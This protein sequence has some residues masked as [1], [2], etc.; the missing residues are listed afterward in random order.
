MNAPVRP[1]RPIEDGDGPALADLWVAAWR[2]SGFA[3]DFEARR[4]WLVERL[5]AHRTAGGAIVV[6]LDARGRPAGFAAIDPATGYLDQLCVAPAEKGAGL[7]AALVAEAKR[8]AVGAV[9]LDVNEANERARRF[10]A[11]EGFVVVGRGSS[12]QSGLPTLR[13]RW[14]PG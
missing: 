4:A 5:A 8:L 12:A 3:I 14:T 1:L 10:Y 13:L 2:D 11:R 7:A 6:G 9:E